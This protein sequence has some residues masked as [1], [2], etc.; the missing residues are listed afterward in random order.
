MEN[1]DLKLEIAEIKDGIKALSERQNA[2]Y[3]EIMM[4]LK[5]IKDKNK[6]SIESNRT[7]DDIYDEA[8]E[9]V[10]EAG[11]ASTS[12]LQR[13]LKIGYARASH[14]LDMLEA[15]GVVGPTQTGLRRE[16]LAK[17]EQ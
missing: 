7:E 17:D 8:R 6:L 4:F 11:F 10:I 5:D 15:N 3:T 16:V 14:L 1:E 9:A 12:Y 13:T 2:Q